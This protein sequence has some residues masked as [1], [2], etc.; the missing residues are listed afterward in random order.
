MT[1]RRVAG[2][3]LA[4]GGGSRLGRP[5]GALVWQGH[6]L[7][8]RARRAL[9]DAGCVPVVVVVQPGAEPADLAPGAGTLVVPNP[10]WAEGMGSSFRAGL[11]A[12]AHAGPE[13]ADVD[14]VVLTLADTPHVRAEH[15]RRLMAAHAGG[16]RVA[17]AAWSGARRTPVLLGREHWEEAAGLAAGDVGARPFLAAHAELVTAVEC[18]DLGPWVDVDSPDDLAALEADV[19]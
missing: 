15:V 5:K 3:V 17:A 18:A 1:A 2:A 7:A 9:A 10:A 6:S 11:R 8:E 4:A 14:A 19:P 16:A 13:R 12:L